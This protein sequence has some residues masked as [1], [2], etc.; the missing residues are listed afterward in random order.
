M[1]PAKPEK[2]SWDQHQV[3]SIIHP[4]SWARRS[5][6]HRV[7]ARRFASDTLKMNVLVD[8]QRRTA[9]QDNHPVF[10]RQKPTLLMA[11]DIA[12][13]SAS[14]I[15]NTDRLPPNASR[16]FETAASVTSSFV[17]EDSIR[18]TS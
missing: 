10:L 17:C 18:E 4:P 8:K 5:Q 16:S 1:L 14:A 13:S 9:M 3:K 15:E 11:D 7:A 12:V 2:P 6:S